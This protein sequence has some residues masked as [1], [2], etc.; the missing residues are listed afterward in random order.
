MKLRY[1]G[2]P[3][4]VDINMKATEWL[5]ELFDADEKVV[6]LDAD[7]MGSLKTKAL[8]EKRPERVFNCGIQEAN[9]VG[10][11]AGLYLAGYKPY[12]HSFT[13]FVT[14]RTYDQL[15]VSI[16]YAGKS[17]HMIG[18]DAGILA[19]DNGGTH[20]C[21]EDV[22]LQRVIPGATI[23][24]VT[25]AAMFHGML[26]ETKDTKGVVYLRTGRRNMP[27]VYEQGTQ[28]HIGEGK[29]LKE[30]TDVTIVASGIMVATALE[31]QKTLAAEG[32][33]VRVVDPVTIKPLDEALIVQ[34]AKETGAIVVAENANILGGLGSAVTEVVSE[35]CPVP[36]VRMGIEDRFG[37]TGSVAYLRK[38]YGLTPENLVEKVHKVLKLK[39][40]REWEK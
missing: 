32:I 20:M 17:I 12:V 36:V 35:N 16:A 5:E 18:T 31:A 6:Y 23:V 38:T 28:F 10:V 34:C 26:K 33:S 4:E 29:V 9:M 39:E 8:W 11:A 2:Q 30:G 37:Q 1:T 27:D 19:S 24:D 21:F 14:R 40:K 7:L 25:D 22:A 13:P 3:A 15:V